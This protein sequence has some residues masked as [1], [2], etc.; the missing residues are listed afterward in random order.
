MS[1]KKSVV[2]TAQQLRGIPGYR[3]RKDDKQLQGMVAGLLYE[4]GVRNY[5]IGQ[6][7]GRDM[8]FFELTLDTDN[9]DIKRVIH[10]KIEIPQVYQAVR[11]KPNKFLP[12]VGWRLFH[13]YLD[14]KMAMVRLGITDLVE[15]FTANIVMRLP[16]NKEGTLGDMIKQGMEHPEQAMLPFIQTR[17][18]EA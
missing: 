10:F 13:D 16:D 4:A 12:Q 5:F 11:G 1:S 18:A 9:P 2:L 15:E 3:T 17:E 6:K 7:E 8:L 14:R